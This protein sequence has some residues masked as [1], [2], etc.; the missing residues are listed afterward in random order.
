MD[1]PFRLLC[2]YVVGKLKKARVSFISQVAKIVFLKTVSKLS[3]VVVWFCNELKSNQDFSHL[4]C[5][6]A[7][8]F[9]AND[10][11]KFCFTEP[12]QHLI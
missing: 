7:N 1:L 3:C 12:L 9:F 2:F 5:G 8:N 11:Q 10:K 4:P 6:D